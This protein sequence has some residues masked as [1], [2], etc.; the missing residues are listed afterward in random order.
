MCPL[1]VSVGPG[2]GAEA[3]SQNGQ[4]VKA[5]CLVGCTVFLSVGRNEYFRGLSAEG[6]KDNMRTFCVSSAWVVP[7]AVYYP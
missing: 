7:A 6:T 3:G 4:A 5:R 1:L 2:G